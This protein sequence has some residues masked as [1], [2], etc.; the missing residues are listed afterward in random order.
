MLDHNGKAYW[1]VNET[2]LFVGINDQQD[3]LEMNFQG[4]SVMKVPVNVAVEIIQIMTHFYG[5]L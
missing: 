3:A 4:T 1:D 2:R 5:K